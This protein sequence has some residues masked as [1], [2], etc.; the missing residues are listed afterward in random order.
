MNE[1]ITKFYKS[2]LGENFSPYNYQLEVAKKLLSG[3]NVILSVPTGAGKTWAS[4]IPFL[5]AKEN[6]EIH[7]PKKMI[8]SLPLRTLANSIFED[9]NKITDS[10]IQT[11]EY[12]ED[13]YFESDIIF[14][15]IDQTLSN[16]LCFPLP[17][18]PR[19]A[20]VNAGSLIGSYLVFDEFHLLDEN[21]S[22]STTIGTLKMLNNL[23]RCCIMTA[24]LS[25]DFMDL[26][27]E[28]LPN[29]E[30]ITL[31][32]F[33]E[34]CSKV[35]SLLPVNDKKKINVI[36]RPISAEDIIN[37]HKSKTIVICNRV[38][39]AQK[40][41][42]DLIKTKILAANENIICLH[43]RFFDLDRK[44][45]EKRLK[46]LFGKDSNNE[47]AILI[48]TQV[49][50]AG[51][52]ISCDIMHTEIS[53]IS[54]FLQR[55]GRCA[56][57]KNQIGEI[58]V[59][60]LLDIDDK[61]KINEEP[62]SKE[63]KA[64]IRKI[65]NKYL[66]YER[67]VCERTLL[68]LSSYSTLDNDIPAKLIETILN[69][70]KIELL[71]NFTNGD[72]FNHSRIKESWTTCLKNNYRNTI[73]DIQSIEITLISD[74]L[75]TEVVKYPYKFQ[76][77]GMYKWSLISWLNKI[78]SNDNYDS[79]D[80]L[81]KQL[82]DN[83]FLGEFEN[84]EDVKFQLTKVTDFM[85][86]PSHVYVNS[87]YLGY[88]KDFGFNWEY[89]NTFNQT[90]PLKEWKS[91]DADHKPL[92]KDTFR[93]HNKGLIAVFEKEFLGETKNNL[94]F[95]FIELSKYIE[96]DLD[97]SDF[98]TM[99]YLMIVLHDYG[100]LNNDW[101]KP[102]QKYQALK[103]NVLI[104]AFKDTL[105]HTDYD[106]KNESD[107][108]LAQKALLHKRPA[109]AGVGAFVSQ[110]ILTELFDNE[111]LTAA[112]P[113][114]IARHH[115]PLSNSYPT[116]DVNENNFKEFKSL[117]NEYDFSFDINRKSLNGTINGFAFDDWEKEQIVYL[118]FVRILRL[119]DQKATE[120][121]E[122]YFKEERHV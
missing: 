49:I 84:D 30:I 115:S 35:G 50:E 11:G 45:K 48:S 106:A 88:S 118:F 38:E 95:A 86:L 82:E 68:E 43:S 23:C 4:T 24:T 20:N 105:A 94:D 81:V 67:M 63:D 14:S 120:D 16:F 17:L 83:S 113:L 89:S 114:A 37:Q 3:K 13:K 61:E 92:T 53:P 60:D 15:T 100:K 22:M 122:K 29:Y 31:D 54:S 26:L 87:K 90:S 2:L 111:Y 56:R 9:V 73:R 8:Y 69:K 34:D 28:N 98:I 47:S 39:T 96:A 101:Q 64:E 70:S 79:E 121:L 44:Q 42:T 10:K 51:M 52:D 18:S 65:N 97:E 27:K 119:C 77:L 6:P 74:E 1:E 93:A 116:F 41:Y 72:W 12:S 91:K 59:Y 78:V 33:P 85:T 62:E 109:H 80:W 21:L 104:E 108:N 25:Q 55:A 103:E 5:Y 99:I 107:K 66:P 112:I 58:Y 102:M 110:Q 71:Q 32:S 76:T 46:Q 36:R 117:L 7:F 19:Q 57:F 75:L 40:L